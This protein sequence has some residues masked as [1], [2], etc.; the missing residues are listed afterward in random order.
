[1]F[2]TNTS[3]P[4][5]DRLVGLLGGVAV[6]LGV[7]ALAVSGTV[8]RS[9]CPGENHTIHYGDWA[10]DPLAWFGVSQMG[11]ENEMLTHYIMTLVPGV[12]EDLARMA[13][14]PHYHGLRDDGGSDPYGGPGGG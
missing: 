7:L 3:S 2:R 11:C 13:G 12:G 1:M 14:G 9:A 10:L 8:A 4:R 5:K 6:G